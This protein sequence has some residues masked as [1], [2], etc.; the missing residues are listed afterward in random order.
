MLGTVTNGDCGMEVMCMMAGLGHD[1]DSRTRLR[2]QLSDFLL[3]HLAEPWMQNIMAVCQEIKAEDLETYRGSQLLLLAEGSQL[4]AVQVGHKGGGSTKTE[5][6]GADVVS[7]D[8]TGEK[9]V[10]A[11]AALGRQLKRAAAAALAKLA[12]ALDWLANLSWPQRW[13]G[14]PT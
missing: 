8:D 12:A 9:K 4:R 3:E 2:S 10:A 13:T 6:A 14:W 11:A 7:I 1:E 5:N